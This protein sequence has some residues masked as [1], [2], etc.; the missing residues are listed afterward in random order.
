MTLKVSV[1]AGQNKGATDSID[2]QTFWAVIIFNY[3]YKDILGYYNI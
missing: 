3:F 2:W 1:T